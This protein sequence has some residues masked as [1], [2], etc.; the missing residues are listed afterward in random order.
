MVSINKLIIIMYSFEIPR[1]NMIR[2][3]ADMKCETY[4]N[5]T[6]LNTNR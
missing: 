1:Q 6:Q 2:T 4:R 3:L 5:C